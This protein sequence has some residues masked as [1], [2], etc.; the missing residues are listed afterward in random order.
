MNNGFSKKLTP[1]AAF[2]KLKHYCAYQERSHAEV[3]EKLYSFGLRKTDVETLIARLIEESY[4]N[5]E[6]FARLFAGGKFRMKKWG[7]VKIRYEM[8]LKQ[9]SEYNIRK[10]LEEIE[11]DEYQAVLQKLVA[12]RWKKLKHEQHIVRQVKTQQY[13]VQKGFEPLLV[14]TAIAALRKNEAD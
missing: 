10:G 1:D 14:K 7:R 4:L 13:L 12:D 3:K 5:E 11:E 9:I 8:K 2:S 6:R